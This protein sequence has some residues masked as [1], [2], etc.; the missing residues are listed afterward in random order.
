MFRQERRAS[1]KRER[2]E[3]EEAEGFTIVGPDSAQHAMDEDPK[4]A[5][6]RQMIEAGMGA[7]LA[8]EAAAKA[9]GNGFEVVNAATESSRYEFPAH[10]DDEDIARSLTVGHMMLNKS[11]RRKMID[12][13]YNRYAWDD[14]E[15]LPAW[16]L[17][18][19][20]RHNKPQMELPAD[21]LV[22][23]RE[24]VAQMANRPIAKVAEA[25]ARKAKRAQ[26]KLKAAKKRAE[27]IANQEDMSANDKKRA[28]D[29]AMKGAK[30]D[31]PSKVY[32]VSRRGGKSQANSKQQGGKVKLVDPRMKADQR[33]LKRKEKAKQKKNRRKKNK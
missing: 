32:V 7:T 33:M 2:E 12:A 31:R 13:S 6:H 9:G 27:A 28:I 18:D 21:V 1:R 3:Q 25:R 16:F 29:K 14:P 19:Q 10:Y 8:R 11:K 24:R 23:M 15:G 20:E 4:S 30:I 22:Q 5:K 26:Q 17:D